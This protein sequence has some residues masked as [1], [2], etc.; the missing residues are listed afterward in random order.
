MK[1]TLLYSLFL[2]FFTTSV[3]AQN[4]KLEV[5]IQKTDTIMEEG[6]VINVSS[7]DAEQENDAMDDLFDDDLDIGYEYVDASEIN[8]VNLGMRFL[9]IT[10]PAGATID[11]AFIVI[12][13]HEGKSATDVANITIKGEKNANPETFTMEALITDRPKTSAS[14]RWEIA[15]EWGL[16]TKH[17]TPDIKSVV[18]EIIG[19]SGWNSGNAI[20]F[21]LEGENQGVSEAENARELESFENIADPEDGGDGQNHPER[22]PQLV[23]YYSEP[24]GT[25][26][27]EKLEVYIQK[28]DTIMEEGVV[29]NVSS[30]D[31]EQENDE[32]DDLYDDDLDIG[33]EYVDAS[34]INIVNLGLRFRGITIPADATIDSA[35]IVI[36]SHE[37][38]SATDEANITIRGEKN[39]NPETFSMEALITDRPK[40]SASVRWEVA[41][42]WGLYTKHR[43]ADIKSVVQEIIGLQGWNSGNAI[44]FIMEGENQ[45]VSE[46]E[47]ARELESFENI[48]D[49][50]DGGDGQN[51]P[52][53]VPQLVVYYKSGTNAVKEQIGAEPVVNVYP[54]PVNNGKLNFDL[55]ENRF[56]TFSIHD[57]T[58]KTVQRG[59]VEST[60]QTID[61]SAINKGIFFIRFTGETGSVTRKI[62]I[63]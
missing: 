30:D 52:E 53:R 62:I 9:G 47:N 2:L 31:A 5:Y 33:Y 23:V 25:T 49:P 11:S 54:N 24:A 17:R 56:E 55:S 1:S 51:H 58:G 34:T 32:M 20:S 26:D 22:V 15:E 46:A 4:K 10:I 18:Q 7:D 37:G 27:N 35:Y 19:L 61:V 12:H 45:G 13:S 41:E 59:L 36:H 50:E 8:I 38:K 63:N 28:T 14:V 60:R 6:V 48:A 39:A 42:E 43:T 29:I 44:A 21:I 57:I 16:Y 3:F 40:T